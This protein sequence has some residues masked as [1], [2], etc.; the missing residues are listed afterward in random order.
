M[1]IRL[2]QLY[3]FVI[4]LPIVNAVANVLVDTLNG[5]TPS[6]TYR[7]INSGNRVVPR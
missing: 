6:R 2:Y 1:L 5:D 7:T 4:R 3:L